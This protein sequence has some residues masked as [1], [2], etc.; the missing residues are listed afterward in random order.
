M[1]TERDPQRDAQAYDCEFNSHFISRRTEQILTY[2]LL[3]NRELFMRRNYAC[4]SE[5]LSY[6]S[7]TAGRKPSE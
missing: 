5:N 2:H 6:F 7:N 1:N 3:K 4:G